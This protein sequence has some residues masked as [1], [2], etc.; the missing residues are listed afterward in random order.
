[1]KRLIV[2]GLGGTTS[3]DITLPGIDKAYGIRKVRDPEESK[4]VVRRI[5]A[6][7][8]GGQHPQAEGG[9]R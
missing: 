6:C 7:L 4:R 1:M 5:V 9:N 3:I 8:A 2:F